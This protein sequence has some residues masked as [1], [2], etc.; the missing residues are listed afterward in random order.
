MVPS[1]A[2]IASSIC[3]VAPVVVDG[4][5]GVILDMSSPLI[6]TAYAAVTIERARRMPCHAMRGTTTLS[7]R[8]GRPPSG[9]LSIPELSRSDRESSWRPSEVTGVTSNDDPARAADIP[10]QRET[11]TRTGAEYFGGRRGLQ[12]HDHAT[13]LNRHRD[14][15]P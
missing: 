14:R 11:V 9:N 7:C 8:C 6:V 2:C 1:A 10:R 12:R 5:I 13:T 3:L 15:H 4:S